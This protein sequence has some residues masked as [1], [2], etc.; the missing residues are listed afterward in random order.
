[1]NLAEAI[2]YDANHQPLTT[3]RMVTNALRDAI[4]R[5]RIRPGERLSENDVARSLG[6]GRGPVREAFIA[7]QENGLLRILPQRGTEV[8]RISVISVENARFIREAIECAIVQAA[9]GRPDTVMR[10]AL[11]ENLARQRKAITTRDVEQFFA[12]DDAFHRILAEGAGR[13][14]VWETL[15]GLRVQMDRVRYLKITYPRS[16][17]PI[18]EQHTAIAEA[19]VRGD[20]RAALRLMQQH[21]RG[22]TEILPGLSER[23]PDM[24]ESQ[25]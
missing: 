5:M 3:A 21:L 19:V 9:A 20:G 14:L 1:M 7:L 22:I 11:T 18:F 17:Q 4:V 23:Y 12:L 24:F 13:E 6:I 8:V 15:Q 25:A 16:M 2:R 10:T